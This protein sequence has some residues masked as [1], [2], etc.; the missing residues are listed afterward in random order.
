MKVC[1]GDSFMASPKQPQSSTGIHVALRKVSMVK[2]IREPNVNI[3]TRRMRTLNSNIQPIINSAPHN[4]IENNIAAGCNDSK[5][6]IDRYSVTL[7]AVPQGS[8][9]FTKPE[10]IN[11]AESDIRQIFDSSLKTFTDISLL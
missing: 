6:Y 5:P 2:N 9:T 4:H 1:H 10:N 7:I 8:I 11:T 3:D